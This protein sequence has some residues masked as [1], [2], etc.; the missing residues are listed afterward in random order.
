MK[1]T[2]VNTILAVSAIAALTGFIAPRAE[3]AINIDMQGAVYNG[4]GVA[5]DTGTTWNA[6]VTNGTTGPLVDSTGG[7]TTVTFSN[8]L[9]DT[10]GNN[11]PNDLMNGYIFTNFATRNFTISGLEFNAAYDLY[12]Y[13]G[14]NN[15]GTA[16]TIG[17]QQLILTGTEAS[18]ASFVATDWGMLTATS[19]GAGV[20]TGTVANSGGQ[21]SAF[22]GLQI[23]PE[24]ASSALAAIGALALLRRRRA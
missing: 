7:L 2:A 20:I 14:V 22:N 13:S 4:I 3:A 12:F 23:I 10:F 24:P 1:S 16:F 15:T 8:D 11:R 6:A 5:P 21:Y 19:S 9:T 17:A 18:S